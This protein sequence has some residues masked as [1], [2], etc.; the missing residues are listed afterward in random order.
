MSNME[1]VVKS[2]DD[3]MNSLPTVSII[4]PAYNAE[5]NIAEL[6][7]SL[8]NQDYPKELFEIIVVDNNSTDR[9]KE[10]VKQYPVKLLEENAVQSSYAARNKGILTAKNEILAFVD[11]DCVAT[12]QWVKEGVKE[13]VSESADLVG[14]NVEFVY[15][16]KK[17]AAEFYDSLIHMQNELYVKEQKTSPTANLFVK[18]PLFDKIGMFPDHVKSGGDIQWT[19]KATRNGFLL[20]YAP[21]AIVKHP[22]RSFGALLKK[23]Y[24]IG[25]GWISIRIIRG[26]SVRDII[27]IMFNLF[28]PPRL[29]YIKEIIH[30]RGTPDMNDKV[31]DMWCISYLCNLSFVLGILASMFSFLSLKA[32]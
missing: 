6:I 29:S 10:I 22:T 23:R 12:P 17:T 2:F 20:V 26:E 18:S 13:L 4:V 28:L 14:G 32:K 25:M 1:D 31:L 30:Q 24:R 16:K 11:S 7:K 5:K 3:V 21:K 8:L 27:Y 15:S 19:S 9:T